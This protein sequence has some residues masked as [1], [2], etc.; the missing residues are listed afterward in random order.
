[1]SIRA[2]NSTKIS[3]QIR[4]G[5][6]SLRRLSWC[7]KAEIRFQ[8]CLQPPDPQGYG[9]AAN[10]GVLHPRAAQRAGH[11]PLIQHTFGCDGRLMAAELL[12]SLAAHHPSQQIVNIAASQ[13][14]FRFHL[15]LT[16]PLRPKFPQSLLPFF[17]LLDKISHSKLSFPNQS[18]TTGCKPVP[19]AKAGAFPPHIPIPIYFSLTS[20]IPYLFLQSSPQKKSC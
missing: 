8:F 7:G 16:F 5:S 6:G 14:I 10:K 12:H 4:R 1:M 9:T 11:I 17:N 2:E 3:P 19:P 15:L 13:I 18:S 20:L